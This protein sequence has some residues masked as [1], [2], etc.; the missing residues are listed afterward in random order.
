VHAVEAA[1]VGRL[2]AAGRA[3]QR[4]DLLVVDRHVDVLQRLEVAVVEV[5]VA[6]LG[7]QW[8]SFVNLHGVFDFNIP[9]G[10]HLMFLRKR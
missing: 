2:A 6:G 8:G 3:D 10:Y 4:G 1:Q 9:W 7:L 5:E